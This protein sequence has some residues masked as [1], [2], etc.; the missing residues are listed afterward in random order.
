MASMVGQLTLKSEKEVTVSMVKEKVM[1]STIVKEKGKM[2]WK[3]EA[4]TMKVV[5]IKNI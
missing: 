3:R 2:T 5:P 1:V 4:N